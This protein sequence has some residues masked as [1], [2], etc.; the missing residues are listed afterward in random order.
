MSRGQGTEDS[1]MAAYAALLLGVLIK[2]NQPNEAEVKHLLGPNALG[3][4]AEL[5]GEFVKFQ[6]MMGM[7]SNQ[8]SFTEVIAYL[9]GRAE[10][11]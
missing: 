7:T 8:Q 3:L 10:T 5:L 4:L 9:S 11:D 1:V 6:G 2:D